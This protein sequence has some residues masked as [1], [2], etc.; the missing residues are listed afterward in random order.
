VIAR[1]VRIERIE[2]ITVFLT[3]ALAALSFA[4]SIG[5]AA[6]VLFG[7]TVSVVNLRLIRMLVS[8]L[9]SPG[10]AGAAFSRLVT[11]KLLL[12]LALLAVAFQKL[13]VDAVWFLIGGGTLFVAIVLEALVLG[14]PV[15]A[16]DG[17][18]SSQPG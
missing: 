5:D 3:L 17:E 14:E 9:M 2:K 10:A 12:L 11:I 4:T 15:V 7:G 18:G 13:P 16:D 8:R 6:S 1:A